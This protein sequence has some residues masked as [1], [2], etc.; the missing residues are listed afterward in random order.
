MFHG[1][2]DTDRKRPSLRRKFPESLVYKITG[3]V[4]DGKHTFEK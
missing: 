1:F 4:C 2:R 3:D